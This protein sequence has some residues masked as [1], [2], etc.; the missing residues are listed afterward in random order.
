MRRISMLAGA[1]VGAVA[2]LAAVPPTYPKCDRAT[3]TARSTT[4]SA[5]RASARSARPTPTARRAS[6]A[7]PT[8]ASPSPSAHGRSNCPSGQKCTA[9][10]CTSHECTADADCGAGRQVPGQPVRAAGTLHHQRGLRPGEECQA[11]ALRQGPR[12]PCTYEPIHF[13][14]N[15]R[16]L[17]SSAADPAARRWPSASSSGKAKVTLEGH[18]DERGTEEYNLQLSNRRAASREAAT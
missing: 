4:R 13:D 1:A 2:L 10:K 3:S 11:G 15:E 7:T 8:S 14:F 6:S 5:S 18:A 17:T 12:D 9:G 16:S